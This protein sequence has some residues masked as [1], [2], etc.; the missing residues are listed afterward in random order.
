MKWIF[1]LHTMGFRDQTTFGDGDCPAAC[2]AW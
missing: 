2:P 1:T